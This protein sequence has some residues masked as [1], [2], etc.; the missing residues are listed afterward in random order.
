MSVHESIPLQRS[1]FRREQHLQITSP[2]FKNTFPHPSQ[3]VYSDPK[4]GSSLDNGVLAVV[5]GSSN[6]GK[7]FFLVCNSWG[8]SCLG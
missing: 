8:A 1:T 5:Y 4:C 6:D 2:S 7:D 3:V